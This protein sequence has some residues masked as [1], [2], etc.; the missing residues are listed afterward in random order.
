MYYITIETKNETN[1]EEMEMFEIGKRYE[2][3][4][5]TVEIISRTKRTITCALVHH[6]GR[7]NERLAEAKRVKVN[8]WD[9]EEVIFINCYEFHA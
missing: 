6:V 7:F 4:G 1:Q 2:D 9:G 5:M 8:N 3:A